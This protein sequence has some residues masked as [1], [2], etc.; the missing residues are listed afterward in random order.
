MIRGKTSG[1]I[2]GV[3]RGRKALALAASALALSLALAGAARSAPLLARL[4]ALPALS[5]YEEALRAA[6]LA[7]IPGSYAHVTD[8]LGSLVV[9][10]GGEG[11]P[12]L[13]AAPL[14]EPG[15]VVSEIDTLGYL[16]LSRLAGTGRLYDQFHVGQR[17]QILT[18]RGPRPAVSA[19]PSVHL[20]RGPVLQPEPM[21]VNDL[22]L[23]AGARSRRDAGRAGIRLLDPV[24]L[25]E[26]YTPLAEGRA[27]GPALEAR[28]EVAALLEA[29]AAGE[30]PR[31][32][33]HW[34]ACFTAQAQPGGRGLRS[35]IRR[36][37]PQA[38]YL[39][40]GFPAARPGAGPAV[41]TDSLKGLDPD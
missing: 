22:W 39:L 19:A 8:A 35:L 11:R 24:S 34:I 36:Y 26:R 30:R 37:D 4:Q 40:G 33:T 7:E 5:G 16:R 31:G 27:A 20:R 12:M 9:D 15:Y 17:F 41:L 1:R 28:G 10:L 14:D 6:V 29:I 13:V 23:D 3:P 18:T 25:I 38:V 21:T 32:G 2:R